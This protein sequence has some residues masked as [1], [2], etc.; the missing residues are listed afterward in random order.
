MKSYIQEYIQ[1]S[2]LVLILK[3]NLM[4]NPN[5]VTLFKKRIETTFNYSSLKQKIW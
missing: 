5:R 1:A 2:N 3:Y 4:P